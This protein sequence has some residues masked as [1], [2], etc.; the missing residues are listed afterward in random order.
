MYSC[1]QQTLDKKSAGIEGEFLNTRQLVTRK[2]QSNKTN[3]LQFN[4]EDHLLIKV[5]YLTNAPIEFNILQCIKHFNSIRS[6]LHDNISTAPGTD[7]LKET[8]ANETNNSYAS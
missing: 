4:N 3:T 8:I 5:G 2:P 1:T 7:H 6:R